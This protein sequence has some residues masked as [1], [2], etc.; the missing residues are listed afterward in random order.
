MFYGDK[1]GFGIRFADKKSIPLQISSE[2]EKMKAL[3][4]RM[5]SGSLKIGNS[6]NLYLGYALPVS[7]P[8]S[9]FGGC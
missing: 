2:D 9:N 4:R 6:C 3:A 8:A 5:K 7:Q 1:P